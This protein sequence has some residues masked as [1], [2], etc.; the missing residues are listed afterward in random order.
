MFIVFVNY[1]AQGALPTLPTDCT[2]TSLGICNPAIA[3]TIGQLTNQADSATKLAGVIAIFLRIGLIGAAVLC[4]LYL[5]WGAIDWIV[6]GGDK[7]ALEAAR[8]KMTHAALGLSIVA[9]VLVLLNFIFFFFLKYLL[10]NLNT[11]P[12]K[13]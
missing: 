7:T 3:N 9:I 11:H 10:I 5:M 12:P 4:L 2:K 6:S 1:L 8:N 13:Y